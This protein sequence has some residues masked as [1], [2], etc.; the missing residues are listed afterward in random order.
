MSQDVKQLEGNW[1]PAQKESPQPKYKHVHFMGELQ[2]DKDDWYYYIFF[3]N[4][5]ELDR[6][7]RFVEMTVYISGPYSGPD[8]HFP[9][10]PQDELQNI[11][12]IDI[13][14]ELNTDYSIIFETQIE[15]K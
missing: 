14:E 15:L 12:R 8:K 9:I 5:Y 1:P 4:Y 7:V 6:E 3:G 13:L 2:D 10:I 11:L